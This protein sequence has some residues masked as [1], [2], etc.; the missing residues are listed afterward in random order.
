MRFTLAL[1][2]ALTIPA[3]AHATPYDQVVADFHAEVRA[4]R[5]LTEANIVRLVQMACYEYGIPGNEW[6]WLEVAAPRIAYRESR[7]DSHA[8]NRT[9][10]ARGL[11]QFLQ[12]WG[13][14]AD[15]LDPV[16]S[17]YRFVQVYRDGGPRKIRQHWALTY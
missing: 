3:V 4:K 6:E 15:R 2:I 17:V 13:D 12:P 9:S 16:W 5:V 14:E 1:L 8:A 10:S 7:F 11:L